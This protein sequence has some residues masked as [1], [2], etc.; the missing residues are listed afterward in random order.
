VQLERTPE[1]L[2]VEEPAG[3]PVRLVVWNLDTVLEVRTHRESA[4]VA[5]NPFF[6][7][8]VSTLDE[9][10]I[11]QSVVSRSHFGSKLS[12]PR[13]LELGD[14]F[15]CPALG[16]SVTAR[17]VEQIAGTLNIALRATLLIHG[18]AAERA[19][20][21]QTLPD[22]RAVAPSS[23]YTLLN[24]PLMGESLAALEARPRRLLYLEELMRL[25]TEQEFQGSR[26]DFLAML[27]MQLTLT[28]ATRADLYRLRELVTRP[29]QLGTGLR[30][31][32]LAQLITS[33][34]HVCLLV[35]LQDQFGDCGT[36]G[37]V[38][39]E[40]AHRRWTL[41][42]FLF[43]CRVVR[44]GVDKIILNV[45]L[46]QAREA[47][48]RMF[49]QF[50]PTSQNQSLLHAY[51]AAGFEQI[52][53]RGELVILEHRLEQFPDLP[54]PARQVSLRLAALHGG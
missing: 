12:W 25:R 43:S 50:K 42:L 40:R 30:D 4:D 15:L 8:F 46:R 49:A 23:V 5:I 52:D 21:T 31:D 13:R 38:L 48:V 39:M 14:Y 26:E 28:R 35:S 7:Q 19:D 36:V 11:L 34:D 29:N 41:Q 24:D 37:F 1:H 9:R 6:R 45:L 27:D 16:V 2:S 20:V 54:C 17:G 32:E 3:R 10:G 22:V 18:D 47:G 44:R 33:P 53:E 51:I